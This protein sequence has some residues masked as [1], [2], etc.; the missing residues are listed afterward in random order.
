MP[1]AF[2]L[3]G[4]ICQ[5]YLNEMG[6]KKNRARYIQPVD[7]WEKRKQIKVISNPTI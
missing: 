7:K 1:Y 3:Y 4:A 2:N 6:R 5:L